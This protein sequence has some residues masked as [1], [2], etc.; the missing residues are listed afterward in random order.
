MK[1]KTF[2]KKLLGVAEIL[3]E[4]EP[5]KKNSHD[6]FA[7]LAR[8][9]DALYDSYYHG[10]SMSYMEAEAWKE[11]WKHDRDCSR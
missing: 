7:D 6:K 8:E 11:H 3:L 4:E 1:L 5:K 2:F 9:T 10:G